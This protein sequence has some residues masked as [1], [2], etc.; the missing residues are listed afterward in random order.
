MT[1]QADSTTLAESTKRAESK[2]QTNGTAQA[3]SMIRAEGVEKSFGQLKV[4]KGVDISVRKSEVVAIVG[5][6]GAR[7]FD[8]L[9]K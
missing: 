5:A 4:L 3:A 6:S 8:T 1:A 7:E 9:R 2:A